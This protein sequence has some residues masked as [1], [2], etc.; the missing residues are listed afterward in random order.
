MGQFKNLAIEIQEAKERAD[1]M[2]FDMMVSDN[3]DSDVLVSVSLKD[4]IDSLKT[5]LYSIDK[6][7]VAFKN[8]NAM[9]VVSTLTPI[10]M[11]IQFNIEFLENALIL[12]ETSQCE[13]S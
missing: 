6:L 4:G 5:S 12:W 1:A 3:I 7:I 2:A 13:P 9:A 11:E 10:R 8:V